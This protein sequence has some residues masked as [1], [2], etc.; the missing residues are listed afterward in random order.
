[1]SRTYR[2][3]LKSFVNIRGNIFDWDDDWSDLVPRT[4]SVR[5]SDK[6]VK[7]C[8]D[9]KAWDKPNKQFKQMNR[10]RDRARV[11]HAMVQEDYENIPTFKNT[12]QWEWT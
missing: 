5:W 4:A 3:Q 10:Q 11:R 2:T 12:D 7:T 9:K 6:L 1:M 8:R